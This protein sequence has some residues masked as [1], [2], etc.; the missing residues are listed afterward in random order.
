MPP[1]THNRHHILA[2]NENG[3][4]HPDNIRRMKVG[5]HRNLHNF[6]GNSYP[7]E[8]INKILDIAQTALTPD[9]V[10]S[11]DKLLTDWK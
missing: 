7:H 10:D 9:F 6:F 3:S 5:D 11:I 8:Q 1:I 4:D 2:R